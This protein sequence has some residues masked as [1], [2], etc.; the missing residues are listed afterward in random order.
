MSYKPFLIVLVGPSG[1]GK[2]TMVQGIMKLHKD[3]KYSISA[4]TR[5]PRKDE[6][7]GKSYFFLDIP[8]FKKWI[9]DD[10]FY[11][12]ALVYDDY[13]GTPKKPVEETIR[14][15]FS[16]ICDLDIQGALSLKSKRS[17]SIAIFLLP[18]SIEE[19][20][21]RLI[22]RGDRD[23]VIN[24]RIEEVEREVGKAVQFDY[25]VR[26]D[27]LEDTIRKIDAIVIAEKHS[28]KRAEFPNKL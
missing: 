12:W 15:G 11:E 6:V 14:C 3:I 2:T 18:P 22:E 10:R 28:T 23:E 20:K 4:T 19:L 24:K 26:N 5:K 17:D 8:T 13:Y 7:D 9:E 27:M 1:V 16:V 21:R 25:I